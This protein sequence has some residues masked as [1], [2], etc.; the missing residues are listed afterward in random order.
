MKTVVIYDFDTGV[1]KRVVNCPDNNVNL[2]LEAGE[3]VVEGFADDSKQM[4]VDGQIVDKDAPSDEEKNTQALHKLRKMRN[5]MLKQCDWTVL[6]DSPLTT[7]KKGLWRTYRQALRD[8][9]DNNSDITNIN[10]VDFPDPP[11]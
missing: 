3:A 7:Y 6:V 9:P 10:Q 1:I 4:V 5:D 2:Q 11:N 8:L